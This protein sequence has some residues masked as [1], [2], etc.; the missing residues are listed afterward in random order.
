MKTEN[1]IPYGRQE[2]TS[3]DINNVINT[4][5]SDFLTQGPKIEEFE[6]DFSNYVDAKYAVAVSNG[7]AAL[8]LCCLAL[9]LKKGD[10]VITSPLTFVASANCIEYCGAEVVFADIDRD[11]YL[12]DFDHVKNLLEDDKDNKIKGIVAVD[13]AGRAVNLEK[14]NKL[15]K[16]YNIWIIED[17]CHA[18]GGYFND[19]N[20]DMQLCGN[21]SYADLSI[22]SFHPVKHIATGEGGMVTTSNKV[23]YEKVKILR[24][25]GITKE[26]EQ[27][28]NT[29]EDAGG[30]EMYPQWY[31]EMQSLGYN[32]RI[33]DFQA[34]LGI[35]QLKRAKYN[36]DKRKEIACRYREAFNKSDYITFK[37]TQDEGHA[38]HLFV[39]ETP[40][41]LELYEYLRS[42]NIYAQVHYYPC[43]L[44]PY[45]KKKGFRKGDYPRAEDYYSKCISLPMYPTLEKEQQNY[46][47]SSINEFFKQ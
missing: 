23:L 29:I 27:F 37:A 24:T 35:S 28:T 47:I 14:F 38:Y 42:K 25:H 12:I 9:G 13:F 46:I 7:T 43:H 1:I 8:H 16:K 10:K 3:E 18:P 6:H 39:I 4:L 30:V 26:V 19:S 17:S 20:N 22:F 15:A 2:I 21:G 31:M 33:T 36:L 5:T 41:R 32:Y 11:T 34:A 44:M 45:Y 40:K